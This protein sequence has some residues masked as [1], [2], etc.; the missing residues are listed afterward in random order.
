MPR[1]L[2][3]F[4]MKSCQRLIESLSRLHPPVPLS[5]CLFIHFLNI[6][7]KNIGFVPRFNPWG[8]VSVSSFSHL[9]VMSTVKALT[10]SSP[11][12]ISTTLPSFQASVLYLQLIAFSLCLKLS[13][14]PVLQNSV[15]FLTF[16]F[17]SIVSSTF[18]YFRLDHMT[19]L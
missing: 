2:N 3:V 1:F 5:T 19:Q 13:I 6:H 7:K 17:L 14:K 16:L 8:S 18:Q 11:G 10:V 9:G 15:P 12:I 4:E